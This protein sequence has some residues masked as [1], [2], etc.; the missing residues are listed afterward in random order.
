M[1]RYLT[2]KASFQD[3]SKCDQVAKLFKHLL[4]RVEEVDEEIRQDDSNTDTCFQTY[5][6]Q[7]TELAN[8][9]IDDV[10]S[11]LN[12][13]WDAGL[14]ID[15]D[16][17]KEIVRGLDEVITVERNVQIDIMVSGYDREIIKLLLPLLSD[18][19]SI[20]VSASGTN[21]EDFQNADNYELKGGEIHY[22]GTTK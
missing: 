12:M 1:E 16:V 17:I 2:F 11:H 9:F 21:D 6:P 7:A 10:S 15:K 14:N 22:K 5:F 8:E 18:F 20:S 4:G 3:E 19:G 13:P